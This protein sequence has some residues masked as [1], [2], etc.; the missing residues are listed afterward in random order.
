MFLISKQSCKIPPQYKKIVRKERSRTDFLSQKKVLFLFFLEKRN[1]G[2]NKK[3]QKTSKRK[4]VFPTFRRKLK[5]TIQANA[6]KT[7]LRKE[8]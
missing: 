2:Q 4:K 7:Q 8:K 6:E 1:R 5:D 3:S